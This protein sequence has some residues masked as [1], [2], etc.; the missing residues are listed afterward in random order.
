MCRI[1]GSTSSTSRRSAPCSGSRRSRAPRSPTCRR[2]AASR[3]W[4]AGRACTSAPWSTTWSSRRRT[5][6]SAAGW[7]SATPATPLPAT[8][9]CN[10]PTPTR[11]A[12]WSPRTCGASCARWRCGELTGRPFSE[13]REAL[14]AHESRYPGLQVVGV[15]VPTDERGHAD[16]CPGRRDAR[17]GLAGGVPRPPPT[18]ALHHRAPGDRLRRAV[19]APRRRPGAGRRDRRDQVP[20]PPVRRPPAALV[21]ARTPGYSGPTRNA[22]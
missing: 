5:P 22:R 21:R 14:D 10:A 11:R 4:W 6:R 12:A 8:P 9:S 13:W 3:C 17:A 18:P 16:R 19:R 2:G 20:H 7:R 1:T 15:D